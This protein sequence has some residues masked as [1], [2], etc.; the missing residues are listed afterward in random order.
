MDYNV[1]FPEQSI[2]FLNAGG[3]IMI[4]VI[5]VI[6]FILLMRYSAKLMPGFTGLLVYLVLVVAGVEIVTYIFAAVPGLNS[7]LFGSSLMFCITRAVI[8]A[9]L[10]HA[11]RWIVIKFSDRNQ[12]L[13]LGDALMGGLGI[14]IGQA[15][16]SGVDLIYLST[17]GTTINTYGM[18]SLLEGMSAEEIADIMESV[19]MTV[20]VPSAYYLCKGLNCALDIVF[21]VIVCLLL[22]AILKKGLP[23]FW[24][25][26]IIISNI[27]LQAMSLFAD[28][29]V[30]E[31]YSVFT[32][33][34][35]L[36]VFIVICAALKIDTDYL[37]NELKSFDKAKMTG[38]LPRFKKKNK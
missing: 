33:I 37:G 8:F 3:I 4:S 30:T 35:V 27:V 23:V 31:N 29:M 2:S 7:F 13:A 11:S 21:Q 32:M 38:S 14:A 1:T 19:N 12:D 22:Y 5:I 34:K 24:H 18:E 15:I 9:L 20:S 36:V 26:V 25:G 28:Y 10:I 17:L 16:I 6:G